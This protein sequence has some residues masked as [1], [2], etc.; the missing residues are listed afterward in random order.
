MLPWYAL[1]GMKGDILWININVD[2]Q[3][4]LWMWEN[5]GNASTNLLCFYYLFSVCTIVIADTNLGK[6]VLN[7]SFNKL[8]KINN[9]KWLKKNH[10][11]SPVS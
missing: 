1:D 3:V 5:F 11:D 9:S 4:R 8:V 6:Y 7:N 2:S 10:R